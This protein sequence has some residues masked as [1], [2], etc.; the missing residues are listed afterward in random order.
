MSRTGLTTRD[1]TRTP[2][3]PTEVS[4]APEPAPAAD[5]EP[6]PPRRPGRDRG[7]VARPRAVVRL[8]RAVAR[9]LDGA[10]RRRLDAAGRAGPRGRGDRRRDAAPAGRRR[11]RGGTGRRPAAD[12][13]G[14]GDPR[15]AAERRHHRRGA[16]ARRRRRRARPPHAGRRRR[17]AVRLRDRGSARRCGGARRRG[18]GARRPVDHGRAHRDPGP[19]AQVCSA[20]RRRRSPVTRGHLDGPRRRHG[21][22][23]GDR[24]AVP[25][26]GERPGRAGRPDRLRRRSSRPRRSTS[27]CRRPSSCADDQG[28]RPPDSGDSGPG[29]P[30][31]RLVLRSTTRQQVPGRLPRRPPARPPEALRRGRGEVGLPAERVRRTV[32]AAHRGRRILRHA[33]RAH[34][35]GE[36]RPVEVRARAD[37][38]R[39]ERRERLPATA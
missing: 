3:R 13:L 7:A 2:R 38:R 25:G 10:G 36:P 21:G 5:A 19:A 29:C 14:R 26:E 12:R 32:L 23:V 4:P 24:R 17:R 11:R 15:V 35:Q 9:R 39:D 31:G 16:G 28:R 33:R 27:R 37:R 1:R 34:G 8:G 18:P 20:D 6:T 22:R 30:G